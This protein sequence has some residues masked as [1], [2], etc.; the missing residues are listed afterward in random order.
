MKC[1]IKYNELVDNAYTLEQQKNLGKCSK[2]EYLKALDVCDEYIQNIYA[3]TIYK[4]FYGAP[5]RGIL[6]LLKYRCPFG[7]DIR[8]T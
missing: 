6:P 2:E 3:L 1:H 5:L 4:E 7:T 8:R